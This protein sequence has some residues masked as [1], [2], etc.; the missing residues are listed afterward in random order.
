MVQTVH[1]LMHYENMIVVLLFGL[2]T[3]ASKLKVLQVGTS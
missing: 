3:Q 1:K 2:V